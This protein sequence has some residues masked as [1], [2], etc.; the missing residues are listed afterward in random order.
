MDE[1][2]Q[3][4]IEIITIF[5][6]ALNLDV[7][8]EKSGLRNGCIGRYNAR[9]IIRVW[10]WG[11]MRGLIHQLYYPHAPENSIQNG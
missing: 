11:L 4:P 1:I 9:C 6:L 10:L 8:K 3:Y 2:L 7:E 5:R